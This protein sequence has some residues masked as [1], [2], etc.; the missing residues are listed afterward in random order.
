MFDFIYFLISFITLGAKIMVAIIV[1]N[2][3]KAKTP[4]I[5]FIIISNEVVAAKIILKI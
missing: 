3:I 4:S 5:K 1:G 2:A